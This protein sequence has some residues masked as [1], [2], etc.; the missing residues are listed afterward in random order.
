MKRIAA[1]NGASR[2]KELKA[3]EYLEERLSKGEKIE[4]E[5]R[6]EWSKNKTG[7]DN[8]GRWLG[9]VYIDGVNIDAELVE[10]GHVEEYKEE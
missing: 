8:F 4:V 3:K 1:G 2:E 5:I 10:R 9:T 7:E 6:P